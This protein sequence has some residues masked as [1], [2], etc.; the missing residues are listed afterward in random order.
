MH[1]GIFSGLSAHLAAN[2][3]V[4]TVDLPGHGRSSGQRFD[5]NETLLE[6]SAH[7]LEMQPA[8]VLGWSLGGLLATALALRHP[9]AVRA[10]VTVA[11]SPC[12][13]AK[14]DWPNAMPAAVFSGFAQALHT[15]WQVV[16]ERFLAL[17]TLGSPNEK[18]ELRWLRAQIYQHGKPDPAAL[19]SGLTMLETIDLRA[20]LG[21]LTM[22]SLWIGGRRDRIVPPLAIRAAGELCGGRTEIL[23]AAHAPF[24]THPEHIAGLVCAIL[25]SQP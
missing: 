21:Q 23:A 20:Q 13:I 15:D 12:F 5:F 22:P 10:L 8:L 17:E 18:A 1:G 19:Q 24:L 25:V 3:T 9:V 4:H 16:V 6:L 7:L 11:S 2:F 14:P